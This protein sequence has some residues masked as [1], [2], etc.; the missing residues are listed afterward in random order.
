MDKYIFDQKFFSLKSF[1][2][3]KDK[4]SLMARCKH[5]DYPYATIYNCPSCG[6]KNPSGRGGCGGIVVVVIILLLISQCK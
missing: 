1:S 4:Y 6:S 5:C 3:F 2:K